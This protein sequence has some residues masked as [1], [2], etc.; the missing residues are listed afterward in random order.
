MPNVEIL[1]F[2][3]SKI[4]THRI[5]ISNYHFKILQSIDPISDFHMSQVICILVAQGAAKLWEIKVGG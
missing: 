2:K 3:K 4:K 5:Q 1:E